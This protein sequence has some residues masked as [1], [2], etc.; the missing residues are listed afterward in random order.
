MLRA[1]STYT[2]IDGEDLVAFV[3]EVRDEFERRPAYEEDDARRVPSEEDDA[4]RPNSLTFVAIDLFESKSVDEQLAVLRDLIGRNPSLTLA[5]DS[6]GGMFT[7]SDNPLAYV[8]DLVCE[9]VCRILVR[10]PAL[11]ARN[12]HRIAVAAAYASEVDES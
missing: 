8:V 4:R 9:V 10:D 1:A 3:L 11:S 5:R 7:Y 12:E 6:A 2:F